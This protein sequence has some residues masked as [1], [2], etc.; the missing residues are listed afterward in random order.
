[1][2]AYPEIVRRRRA[3]AAMWFNAAAFVC[4]AACAADVI[5]V[6]G[7]QSDATRLALTGLAVAAVA[8]AFFVSEVWR[9]FLLEESVSEYVRRCVPETLLTLAIPCAGAAFLFFAPGS[10]WNWSAG[11]WAFFHCATALPPALTACI[12][13]LRFRR[14][15]V[16][17]QNLTPGRVFMLSF[18]ALIAAGTL[19][20]MTP[21]ATVSGIAFTDAL[22]FATSAVCVTGLVPVASLPETLTGFGQCIILALAQLGGLGVMAITYFFA[23]FFAGGLSIRNRF[24]FQDL[25]SEENMTQIGLVLGVLVGFTLSVEA[26]GAA[27]IYFSF[28]QGAVAD[29]IF[30]SVFHS[31]MAFCNAGF[32]TLPSGLATPGVP[33][34][35][36]FLGGIIA[37]SVIGGIGFPVWKNFFLVACDSL[38]RRFSRKLN[39]EPPVRLST[40]TKIVIC[41]SAALL[42]AGVV[43]LLLTAHRAGGGIGF[44]RAF[45]LSATTRTAGFDIGD[46]A[47]L[48]TGTLLVMMVLMFIG[49]APFSTAGGIKVTTFAVAVLALRQFLSGNRDLEIFRRRLDSDVANQAL[50]V[51]LLSGLLFA[52]VA[53]ALCMLH[54]E[55]DAEFLI[56]E[57]VSAVAT[58]GLSCDVTPKLCTEAKLLLTF[59]M[60]V[61]RIGVLV[62]LASFWRRRR[63]TGAR[64]PEDTIVLT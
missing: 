42:A 9:V 55:L 30:F 45:F 36:V 38:R 46:P 62:F 15:F 34:C 58:V 16:P 56:F 52:A 63:L 24:A 49:G 17:T 47:L 54:P 59:A 57:A 37:L 3:R 2:K 8:L 29:P 41:T 12:R 19:L 25:F 31:V 50:V 27:W 40:H 22:F 64:F 43:L 11:T 4:A 23:Y 33:D 51:V 13:A 44:M 32:S 60:F 20:L 14:N 6:A 21:R 18:A 61:G 26:V 1:M 5:F 7:W 39:A 48:P 10:P 53:I 28:A 35:T